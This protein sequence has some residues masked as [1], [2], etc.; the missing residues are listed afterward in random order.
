V[1]RVVEAAEGV[2]VDHGAGDA[3]VG[4]EHPGLGLDL[5]GGEDAADRGE[6]RVAVE[7][8]EVSGQLLDAADAVDTRR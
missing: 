2:V 6:Q 8:L 5:L 1:A 4:G 3:A 7:Q